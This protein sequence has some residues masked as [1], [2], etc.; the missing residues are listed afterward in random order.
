MELLLRAD[1]AE[2]VAGAATRPAAV[3]PA[4]IVLRP[5]TRRPLFTAAI[6]QFASTSCHPLRVET[7]DRTEAP[8]VVVLDGLTVAVDSAGTWGGC[9]GV[10]LLVLGGAVAPAGSAAGPVAAW[11]SDEVDASTFCRTVLDV[12]RGIVLPVPAVEQ[13]GLSPREC[14]VLRLIADGLTNEEIAD[15]VC[16]SINTVKTYVRTAYR[17]IGVTSRAQAVRWTMAPEA[18]A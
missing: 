10:P 11:L 12:S 8:D 3:P 18:P 9:E 17:K 4:T 15:Q 13:H 5:L 7:G 1:V 2:P 6:Q 16:L 14:E